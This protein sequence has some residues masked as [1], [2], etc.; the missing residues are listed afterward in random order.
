MSAT[1]AKVEPI[2]VGMPALLYLH[3]FGRMVEKVFG[4]FP[5]LVGSALRGKNPRDI[6]VRMEV[7][8][9]RFMA[10]FPDMTGWNRAGSQW[11]VVCMA[12]SA[13]GEKMTGL[14]ID[15][16]IQHPAQYERHSHEPR[17]EL[18]KERE[19]NLGIEAQTLVAC[20]PEAAAG[21][22]HELTAEI[23]KEVA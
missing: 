2:G 12:F 1:P 8:D 15:F 22:K 17:L 14:P 23:M 16:Q 11:A 5:Y 21:R 10:L 13:L 18:G 7:S 4:S 3:E 20:L 9:L 6:D 19:L